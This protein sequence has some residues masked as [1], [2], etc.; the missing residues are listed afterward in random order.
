MDSEDIYC[1]EISRRSVA[2]AALHLG[3]DSM[4]QDLLDV[5]SDV[6]Q[7]YVAKIGKT[8]AFLVESAGRPSSHSNILDALQAIQMTTAPAA[9]QVNETASVEGNANGSDKTVLLRDKSSAPWQDLAVFCFGSKWEGGGEVEG[10]GAGK[11]GPSSITNNNGAGWRAPFLEEIPTFPTTKSDKVANPHNMKPNVGLSLHTDVDSLQEEECRKGLMD[12][13]DRVF[14][15]WGSPQPSKVLASKDTAGHGDKKADTAVSHD[16][17]NSNIMNEN[18]KRTIQPT[19]DEQKPATKKAKLGGQGNDKGNPLPSYV[20]NFMPRFPETIHAGRSIVELPIDASEAVNIASI[21][22]T[23]SNTEED[24][25]GVR[26]SLVD[27]GG[28]SK[29]H[30][31]WGSG[32]D[33]TPKVPVGRIET[34]EKITAAVIPLARA[35]NSRVSRILEGSMD[36]SH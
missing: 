17:S 13:P 7:Q 23:M 28:T 5:L 31:Y 26:S 3:I 30:T 16:K 11:V 8:M 2:R 36:A 18:D 10:P 6:L 20:P 4:S 24:T 14:T 1:H 15:E 27:L 22:T 25:L 21:A 33:A 35:S 34:D 29:P 32:W 12:I 19:T 9:Y